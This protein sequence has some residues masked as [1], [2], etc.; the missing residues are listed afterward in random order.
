[1]AHR[2]RKPERPAPQSQLSIP[3]LVLLAFGL[4]VGATWLIMRGSSGEVEKPAIESFIPP[5][6]GPSAASSQLGPAAP[7]GPP[8][9]S[10][11]TPAE[12]ARIVANWNYDQRDWAHAIEHY[13]EAITRGA[14]NPDVRT[15]FGNC[16]RF[17]GQPQ[18]ALE[19]YEIAQK[20]NPQHENSLF[21]EISL[22]AEVLHDDARAK[23]AAQEF[24]ARFPQS[25]RAESVRQLIL[26]LQGT[27]KAS[28]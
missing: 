6:I 2:P 10:Q 11:L 5:S 12:A 25:P 20:E 26:Q 1:M 7:A 8:D 18:K 19:Q 27:S 13:Q 28:K 15:D 16:F 4:G 14:D 17:L 3:L 22:F 24:V 9:V 23:S 21:N